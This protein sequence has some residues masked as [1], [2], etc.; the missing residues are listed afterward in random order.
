MTEEPITMKNLGGPEPEDR[1][2]TEEQRV[3]ADDLRRA[4]RE[5]ESMIMS[6]KTKPRPDWFQLLDLY[7]DKGSTLREIAKMFDVSHVAVRGWLLEAEIPLR[8]V[9]PQTSYELIKGLEKLTGRHITFNVGYALLPTVVRARIAVLKARAEALSP[10]IESQR[11][12]ALRFGGQFS[13][14]L[15]DQQRKFFTEIDTMERIL[16][17]FIIAYEQWEQFRRSPGSWTAK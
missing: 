7:V 13:E 8:P 3:T 14:D 1:V 9:G 11:I 5:A 16:G 4:A 10:K 12:M 6:V 2:I 17:E 15:T